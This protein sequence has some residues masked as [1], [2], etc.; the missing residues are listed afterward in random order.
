VFKDRGG[1]AVMAFADA[2]HMQVVF[3]SQTDYTAF[4]G[5]GCLPSDGA[6]VSKEEAIEVGENLCRNASLLESL[7]EKEEYRALFRGVARRS[8][9]ITAVH[10]HRQPRADAVRASKRLFVIVRWST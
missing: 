9:D 10:V 4:L 8:C 6:F 7:R 5:T 3:I 2:A 1:R